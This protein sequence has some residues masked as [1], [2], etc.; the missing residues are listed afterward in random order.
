MTPDVAIKSVFTQYATFSGRAR[1][2]EYW[3]FFLFNLIVSV[4]VANL[5]WFASTQAFS[6]VT[7]IALFI[8]SIAVT[9]RRFHD[10]G[11]SGWWILTGFI[12]IV[13]L[14]I[15][16]AFTLT[17]SDPG[18]NSYGPSPK[19]AKVGGHHG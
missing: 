3:W 2:S 15:L 1:R 17:D 7:A 10:V 5:D 12:P 4:A 13:G 14:I 18:S 6:V 19:H 16:I 9:V 11:R 8:P